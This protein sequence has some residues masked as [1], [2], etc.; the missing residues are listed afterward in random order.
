[1]L[2]QAENEPMI[3]SGYFRKELRYPLIRLIILG[4]AVLEPGAGRTANTLCF[5]ELQDFGNQNLCVRF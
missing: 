5:Q 1:M 2:E 3:E 4:V